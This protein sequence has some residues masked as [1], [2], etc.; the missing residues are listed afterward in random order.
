VTG[1]LYLLNAL[2]IG[3]GL[4]IVAMIL[5]PSIKVV[6]FIVV[7]ML[8]YGVVVGFRFVRDAI[9]ETHRQIHTIPPPANEPIKPTRTRS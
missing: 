4:C 2:W 7:M 3:G 1:D 8:P 5:T 6:R 9:A